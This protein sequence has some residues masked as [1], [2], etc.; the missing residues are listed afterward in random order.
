MIFSAEITLLRVNTSTVC[1]E[2][3][4]AKKYSLVEKTV[5][6]GKVLTPLICSPSVEFS[7]SNFSSYFLMLQ[8]MLWRDLKNR[9]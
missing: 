9:T 7:V 8:I 5:F 2:I 3:I 6:V 4:H 1:C